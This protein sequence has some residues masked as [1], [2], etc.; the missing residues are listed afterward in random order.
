M[1]NILKVVKKELN[2]FNSSAVSSKVEQEYLAVNEKQLNYLFKVAKKYYHPGAKF[3][4]IG[5]AFAY[6]CLGAKLIGYD[7]YGLDSPERVEKFKERFSN[8]S[9]VNLAVDLARHKSPFSSKKFDIILVS[10]IPSQ[11][12]RYPG[13]FFYEI[14]RLLK[15]GGRVIITADNLLRLKNFLK[16]WHGKE[17]ENSHNYFCEFTASE[18]SYLLKKNGLNVEKIKYRN[19]NHRGLTSLIIIFNTLSGFFLPNRRK[20]LVVTAR[21]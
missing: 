10:E 5:S 7:A 16:M 15:P 12:N 4:D 2:N 6:P 20:K 19:F 14:S 13:R 9:L 21:K 17:I 3:L 8:F 11:I 18:L 1:A